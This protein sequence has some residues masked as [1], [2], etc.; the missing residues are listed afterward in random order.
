MK[1]IVKRLKSINQ[2]SIIMA[3]V[4]DCMEAAEE[5][6]TLRAENASMARALNRIKETINSEINPDKSKKDSKSK[7]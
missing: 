1:D 3:I 2:E 5:I 4:R 7:K 6:E